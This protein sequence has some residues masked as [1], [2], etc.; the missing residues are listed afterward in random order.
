MV[1]LK[2]FIWVADTVIYILSTGEV[3]NSFIYL[4]I[5]LFIFCLAYFWSR[6]LNNKNFEFFF[7]I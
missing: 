3:K 7:V 6:D 4:F 5:Y 2:T 1:Y